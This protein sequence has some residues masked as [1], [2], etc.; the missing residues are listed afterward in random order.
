VGH[1]DG[2]TMGQQMSFLTSCPPA[3]WLGC[4]AALESACKHNAVTKLQTYFVILKG[5]VIYEIFCFVVD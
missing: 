3:L 5:T 1:D 4:L 2:P